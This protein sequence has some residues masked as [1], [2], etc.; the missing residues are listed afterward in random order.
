[1]VPIEQLHFG[2]P[3]ERVRMELTREQ[4]ERLPRFDRNRLADYGRDQGWG[5]GVRLYR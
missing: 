3:G 1:V 2:A 5:D 4:L